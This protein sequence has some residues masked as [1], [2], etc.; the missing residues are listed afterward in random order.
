VAEQPLLGITI[1]V[2]I[3]S[4]E[5]LPTARGSLLTNDRAALTRPLW[6]GCA[7]PAR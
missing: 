4:D 6:L 2:K 5:N 1:A 3:H 7:R